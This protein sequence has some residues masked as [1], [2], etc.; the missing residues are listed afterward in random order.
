MIA[1]AAYPQLLAAQF[2][3]ESAWGTAL[4]AKNNFF[5]I[6]AASSESATVSNTREVING[7]SVYMD[8]RFKNFDTPQDAVNHLVTQWYKDYKGYKGVNNAASAFAAA[9]QLRAEGY[10]TDPQYASSLKRLMNE[11]SGVTGDQKDVD[12]LQ[13]TPT[14]MADAGD[15]TPST[16]G[17]TATPDNSDAKAEQ[18]QKQSGS[19]VPSGGTTPSPGQQAQLSTASSGAVAASRARN[20][21]QMTDYEKISSGMK[22]PSSMF[23]PIPIGGP[24]AGRGPMGGGGGGTLSPKGLNKKESIEAFYKAQLLGFLQRQ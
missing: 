1:G 22:S 15:I 21:S 9:D 16:F 3:L 19:S 14:E 5:G 17:R 18:A 11:Y 8:E 6:K 23:M 4:S 13:V 20:I 24:G 12:S 2:A 7:Q 10:A